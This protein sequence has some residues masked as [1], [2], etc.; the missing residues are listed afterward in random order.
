MP[1]PSSMAAL[2]TLADSPDF[3]RAC[4]EA[5][6]GRAAALRAD[7]A[8][9]RRFWEERYQNALRAARMRL[10]D[11]SIQPYQLAGLVHAYTTWRACCGRAGLA[12]AAE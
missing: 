11:G 2:Y 8:A 1:L 7:K 6:H 3:G 12:M 10:R 5:E 4:F 9:E